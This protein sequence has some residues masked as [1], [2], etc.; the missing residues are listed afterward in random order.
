MNNNVLYYKD[1]FTIIHYDINDKI[2]YG[3]IEGIRDLVDFQSES[4]K[5]IEKEFQDAVDD[6]LDYCK[7]MNKVPEK[8]FK[9]SFNVRINPQLH[10]KLFIQAESNGESMNKMLE[11][12][13]KRYFDST[14]DY[15]AQY[16]NTLTWNNVAYG[17]Q[18][19]NRV[20]DLKVIYG[21]K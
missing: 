20:C 12:I 5:T 8:A 18:K 11:D 21:G 16:Q 17:Q 15:E 14:T 6:Y 2:L 1:Y 9:G 7:E 19:S 4:T 10:R 3:K 13:I